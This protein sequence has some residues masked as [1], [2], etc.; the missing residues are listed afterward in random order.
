MFSL[1]L[2]PSYKHEA[3][4]PWIDQLPVSS[5]SKVSSFRKSNWDKGLPMLIPGIH[6]P[7]REQ[8]SSLQACWDFPTLQMALKPWEAA[9]KRLG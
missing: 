4:L 7:M 6:H 2:S 5:P 8:G 9:R 1:L 3:A